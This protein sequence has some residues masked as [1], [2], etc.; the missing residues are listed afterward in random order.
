MQN[1]VKLF[2]DLYVIIHDRQNKILRHKRVTCP[3]SSC[4]K[5]R[6]VQI[7][8]VLELQRLGVI[9]ACSDKVNK[10]RTVWAPS[11]QTPV[12]TGHFLSSA[13]VPFG[14]PKA[15]IYRCVSSGVKML[16]LSMTVTVFWRKELAR[17]DEAQTHGHSAAM[18]SGSTVV[19]W[20]KKPVSGLRWRLRAKNRRSGGGSVFAPRTSLVRATSSTVTAHNDHRLPSRTETVLP[21]AG[22]SKFGASS[23]RKH[24]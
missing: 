19:S 3:L 5:A 15:P 1:E 24:I 4:E 10:Y 13:A 14:E 22:T 6:Q 16:L 18:V 7:K 12:S 2:D 11:C 17:R 23:P 20:W 9:P 21:F 8:T